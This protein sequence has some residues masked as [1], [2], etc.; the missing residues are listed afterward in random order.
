MH[1]DTQLKAM[2]LLLALLCSVFACGAAAQPFPSKPMRFVVPYA[3][4]GLPDVMARLVAQKMSESVGQ[5]IVVENKPGASGII[6]VDVVMKSAADG[7]TLLVG[8]IAQY[9]LNPALRQN[10]SYDTLRD[11]APITHALRGPLFL[12]VNASTGVKTVKEFVAFAKA[13]PGLPYGSSGNASIHQLAMEQLA[14]MSSLSLVHIP[15]KGVGQAVPAL[16]AGDTVAMFVSPN[17]AGIGGH[18]KAGKVNVLAVAYSQRWPQLADVPTMAEAGFPVEAVTNI[19]FFA[20]AGTPA[21]SVARLHAEL[22]RALKSPDVESKMPDL[23][24]VVVASTPEEF[25]ARIRADQA[26]YATLTRQIKVSV[27]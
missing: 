5:S 13:K 8:D 21:T 4:G 14:L 18:V 15:Y 17:S 12:M 26:I 27:D 19:G 10:L 20:P 3:P 22:V 6:A 24:A 2:R 25:V 23:G 9:A 7:H 11:F 16:L 1:R